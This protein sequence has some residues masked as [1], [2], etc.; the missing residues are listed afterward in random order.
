M[1]VSAIASVNISI[2]RVQDNT[3]FAMLDSSTY[4]EFPKIVEKAAEFLEKHDIS[5]FNVVGINW[6]E[7]ECQWVV[8]FYSDYSN[9]EFINVWV[10]MSPGVY[11]LAGHSFGEPEF[12]I[13]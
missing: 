1:G 6:D 2:Y 3:G 12:N 11:R 5:D 13:N 8:S 4:S 9:H 7:D 10:E